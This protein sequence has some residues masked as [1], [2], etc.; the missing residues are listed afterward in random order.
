MLKEQED[1][2]DTLRIA[3]DPVHN[4]KTREKELGSAAEDT[5]PDVSETREWKRSR[6]CH[7]TCLSRGVPADRGAQS[8]VRK[9]GS[10]SS[11]GLIQQKDDTHRKIQNRGNC[12]PH[13][14]QRVRKVIRTREGK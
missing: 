11:R 6:K 14:C 4:E 10:A 7:Q 13:A 8:Q 9:D 12:N 3:T 1:H 5:V 2:P